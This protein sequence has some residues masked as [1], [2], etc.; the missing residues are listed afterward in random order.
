MSR[1]VLRETA[2]L[3]GV[4][5]ATRARAQVRDQFFQLQPA[6]L[7]LNRNKNSGRPRSDQKI[8]TIGR[9]AMLAAAWLQRDML[10]QPAAFQNQPDGGRE[11]ANVFAQKARRLLRK[12]AI[13]RPW[14]LRFVGR[15]QQSACN[16]ALLVDR[17]QILFQAEEKI[18]RLPFRE[19]RTDPKSRKGA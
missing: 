18:L 6:A 17:K 13:V 7:Y 11:L 9:G 3:M 10:L 1:M 5:S 12:K 19:G 8:E 16:S 4:W 15:V 2:I 14:R